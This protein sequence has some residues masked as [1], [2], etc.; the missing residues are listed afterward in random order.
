MLSDGRVVEFD[1]PGILLSNSGSYFSALVEQTGAAEAK[2][3]QLLARR[4]RMA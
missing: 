3:L 4:K 2:Y 1:A